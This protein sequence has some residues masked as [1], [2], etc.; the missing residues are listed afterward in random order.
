MTHHLPSCSVESCGDPREVLDWCRKH[1]TR[2]YRHG[3]PEH[4]GG[5]FYGPTEDRFWYYTQKQADGHWMWTGTVHSREPGKDYGVLW[6]SETKERVLA[7]RYSYEL[8]NGPIP[9]GAEPDHTCRVPR[10]VAPRHL[11]AVT[12]RVNIERAE[13][14]ISTINAART[15]CSEGHEY[16][17]L[18]KAGH[19]YCIRC[20]RAGKRARYARTRGT[21]TGKGGANRM[22]ATCSKGH[23]YTPEN[24]YW[25]PKNGSRDC[26]QCRRDRKRKGE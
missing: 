22:K 4:R 24:T 7:H 9:V 17:G 19:R 3:D 14:A 25:H 13:N 26:K 20:R 5:A 15:T 23:E 6:N 2:W 10:C 12:H 21:G 1:Y 18:D 8:H 16:D 11:E